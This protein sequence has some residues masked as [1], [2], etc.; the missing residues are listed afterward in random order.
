MK[1]FKHVRGRIYGFFH[2]CSSNK[3]MEVKRFMTKK[4]VSTLNKS[5]G[6]LYAYTNLISV[7]G[8]FKTPF[9]NV[10]NLAIWLT[11]CQLR[12]LPNTTPCVAK[13]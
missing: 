11:D 12:N 4:Y 7:H 13:T 8:S 3:S 10:V 9:D 6:W 5:L 2:H 1:A